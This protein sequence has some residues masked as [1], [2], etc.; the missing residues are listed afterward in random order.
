MNTENALKDCQWDFITQADDYTSEPRAP[1]TPSYDSLSLAADDSDSLFG[2]Q[3]GHLASDASAQHTGS[4][5][6]TTPALGFQPDPTIEFSAM[7]LFS[8]PKRDDTLRMSAEQAGFGLD[9]PPSASFTGE[10]LSVSPP[11][12]P[13]LGAAQPL[14]HGG[15]L[16]PSPLSRLAIPTSAT[17]GEDSMM[18]AGEETAGPATARPGKPSAEVEKLL[19]QLTS[20]VNDLAPACAIG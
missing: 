19:W 10:A 7:P 9:G 4:E 17:G 15:T 16:G 5:A 12:S 20:Q 11:G 3:W 6:H 1:Y 18:S 2:G 14:P 13:S 8:E